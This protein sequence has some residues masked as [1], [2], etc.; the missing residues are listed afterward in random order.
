MSF[1]YL[2]MP[3]SYTRSTIAAI[4]IPIPV[5]IHKSPTFLSF[6][7]KASIREASNIPPVAPKGCPS[8][9]APPLTFNLSKKDH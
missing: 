7:S 1:V 5:G 6:I 8:A 4:P 9:I 2:I 3:R